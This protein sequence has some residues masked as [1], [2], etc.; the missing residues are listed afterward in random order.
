MDKRRAMATKEDTGTVTLE[1]PDKQYKDSFIEALE[2]FQQEGKYT[3]LNKDQMTTDFEAFIAEIPEIRMKINHVPET[4]YWL[5]EDKKYIGRLSIRHKLNGELLVKG[6]HI[7][8]SIRPSERRKGYGVK[9]LELG[10]EKAKILGLTRILITCDSSNEA[11]RK[12]I[13]NHGGVLENEV[14]GKSGNPTI[15]RFWLDTEK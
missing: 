8:Y 10:L 14:A 12:I 2:E 5:I 11:S 3:Y 13:E 9:I 6:G 7:G 1:L 4:E 15:L